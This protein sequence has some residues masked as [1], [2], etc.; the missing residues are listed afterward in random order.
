LKQILITPLISGEKNEVVG[1]VRAARCL[2]LNIF[3]GTDPKFTAND[4]FDSVIVCQLVELYAAE[5]ITVVGNGQCR[6][7]KVSRPL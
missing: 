4:G 1:R 6:Q 2:C 3:A 5:K 7:P